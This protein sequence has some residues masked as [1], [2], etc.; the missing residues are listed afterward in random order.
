MLKKRHKL[1]EIVSKLRQVDVLTSQGSMVAKLIPLVG[2]FFRSWL[3]ILPSATGFQMSSNVKGF[4][5]RPIADL[6]ARTG[7]GVRLTCTKGDQA[8]AHFAIPL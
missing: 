7:A 8:A 4:G 1:E 2:S 6:S 5:W 3:T